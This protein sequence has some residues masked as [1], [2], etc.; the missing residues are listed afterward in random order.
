MNTRPICIVNI[1][2]TIGMICGI[3]MFHTL[4]QAAR[5]VDAGRL[6]QV[7]VDAVDRRYVDDGSV[8]GPLPDAQQ[9]VDQP[10]GRPVDRQPV[11][12]LKSDRVRNWVIAPLSSRNSWAREQQTTADTK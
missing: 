12:P 6:V 1:M 11:L 9:T 7:V 4:C 3:V 8:T 10:E 5:P 2:T